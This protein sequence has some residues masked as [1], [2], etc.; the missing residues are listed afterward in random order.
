MRPVLIAA[1]FFTF[2]AGISLGQA[3]QPTFE[4][5][6]IKPSAPPP[7][8]R[9][10][11]TRMAGGPGSRDPGQIRW[12]NVTVADVVV[13]AYGLQRYQLPTPEK[14]RSAFSDK[15]DIVANV[16][17]GTTM[18]QFK[19]MMQNLL[20]ERF[21][22]IV[23]WE[24]QN[25]PVYE[26]VV[27]KGGLKIRESPDGA[28]GGAPAKDGFPQVPAGHTIAFLMGT[29]RHVRTVAKGASLS[30]RPVATP[31]CDQFNLLLQGYVPDLRNR[32]ILDKTG[33]TRKYD[34]TLDF[35]VLLSAGPGIDADP[36]IDGVGIFDALEHQMG[37]KLV[38]SKASL[39]VLVVDHV[40]KPSDN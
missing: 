12:E 21:H 32:A 16:P 4:V 38:E 7:T 35:V 1:S 37:L 3:G 9:R 24:T 39:D 20:R 36:G 30:C 22:V 19:L 33:L 40:E 2:T 17:D 26:L 28:P 25:L 11:I 15:Y 10:P 34:F 18:V 31:D 8:G 5:V 27:A 14:Y 6:S 29:D 23:H 13:S